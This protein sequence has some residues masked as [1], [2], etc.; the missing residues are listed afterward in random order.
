MKVN[1]NPMRSIWA[2]PSGRSVHI[3]DQTRLP[4]A[5]ETC[6]LASTDEVAHAIRS[7]Q[8][9]GAPLI[10]AIFNALARQ[11]PREEHSAARASD[12]ILPLPLPDGGG[13]VRAG[14]AA[15][16]RGQRPAHRMLQTHAM[17]V[18]IIAREIVRPVRQHNTTGIEQPVEPFAQRQDLA[19]FIRK[20]EM[21][22][23]Q[24][25]SGPDGG[26][27]WRKPVTSGLGKLFC[28]RLENSLARCS[29]LRFSFRTRITSRCG[30]S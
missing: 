7:M 27:A 20:M 24:G 15:L 2:D 11:A 28:K 29:R 21:H 10:G 18:A 25:N 3:I 8:V 14:S 13:T 22:R 6:T 30:H 4:F 1:G 19:L 12:V 26:F 16:A 17:D 5:F 23:A 9:R